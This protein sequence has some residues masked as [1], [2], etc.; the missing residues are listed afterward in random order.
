[1]NSF[2]PNQ[3]DDLTIPAGMAWLMGTCMESRGKQEL[4][5]QRRP[6]LLQALREMAIIKSAESSNRLEGVTIPAAR[7]KP[8]L[9]GDSKPIDRSEEELLGY[10][11]ALSYI[12]SNAQ[13]IAIDP[14]SIKHLHKLAQGGQLSGD[15]GEWK[16]RNNEIIELYPDGRRKI[17]FVPTSVSKTPEAVK[18]LCLAYRH[19]ITQQQLPPLLAAASFVFDFLCIHPFRDG[20]GRVSRLITLLLLY[21]LGYEVG[22]YVSLE[23]IVEEDKETYYSVLATCSKDWHKGNHTVQPWW[24]FFLSTLRQSYVELQQRL[25]I[26]ET[27]VG[28]SE[29]VRQAA[30]SQ[31]STFTLKELKAL[32]PSVSEQLIRKILAELKATG[33]LQLTGRGRGARWKT[34]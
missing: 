26:A 13:E 19:V 1:M 27:G 3:L 30:L 8:V 16:T 22:R 4:W 7:L 20:N 10:R 12:H 2:G 14:A 21:Q 25:D 31:R 9:L 28:K 32:C 5:N 29:L 34:R 15:A 6:E 11:K 23:R 17:R 18:Q 33:A 24:N